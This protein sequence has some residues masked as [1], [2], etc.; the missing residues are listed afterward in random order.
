M[1]EFAGGFSWCDLGKVID[2][3]D[4]PGDHFGL[5]LRHRLQ[6]CHSRKKLKSGGVKFGG[7]GFRREFAA[8]FPAEEIC[9]A[10]SRRATAALDGP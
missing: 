5:S 6:R 4:Q 10:L 3:A 7:V 1:W 9:N 8:V 2:M